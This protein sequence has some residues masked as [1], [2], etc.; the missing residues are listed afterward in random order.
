MIWLWKRDC[1]EK[2]G[3]IWWMF[4]E[5]ADLYDRIMDPNDPFFGE[6]NDILS[7][8][9]FGNSD[10]IDGIFGLIDCKFG[11]ID[12]IFISID[13]RNVACNVSTILLI[14]LLNF[15]LIMIMP[16]K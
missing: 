12:G 5:T 6:I 1:H 8:T 7:L 13:R 10:L 4:F 9:G 14:L 11:S 3:F 16:C 2:S 15:S